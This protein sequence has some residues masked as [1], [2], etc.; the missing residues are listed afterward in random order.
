MVVAVLAAS[1]FI[2]GLLLYSSKGNIGQ[3]AR[4]AGEGCPLTYPNQSDMMTIVATCTCT[5]L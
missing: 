4:Q 1:V 3:L 5:G 2:L